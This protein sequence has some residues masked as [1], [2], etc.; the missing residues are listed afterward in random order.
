MLRASEQHLA[1]GCNG[2]GVLNC[3][4]GDTVLTETDYQTIIH[5]VKFLLKSSPDADLAGTLPAMV[6]LLRMMN[7]MNAMVRKTGDH[8]QFENEAW[9]HSF[10]LEM[11][12]G[13]NILGRFQK[14]TSLTVETLR[15]TVS[16]VTT[17]I[18][19]ANHDGFYVSEADGQRR[20][21]HNLLSDPFSFHILFHRFLA[22]SLTE[23]AKFGKQFRDVTRV[24]SSAMVFP[25]LLFSVSAVP[26]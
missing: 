3:E 9:T 12:V 16:A 22:G 8:M 26:Q 20:I 23:V 15:S 2:D 6:D 25:A 5:D 1:A 24:R 19:D 11:Q 7:G 10:T 4:P 18:A 14:G 17:A 21:K 13:L